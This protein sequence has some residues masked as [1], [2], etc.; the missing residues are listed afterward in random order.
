MPIPKISAP[1]NPKKQPQCSTKAKVRISAAP[2]HKF[3]VLGHAFHKKY[4]TAYNFRDN[5]VLLPQLV[6]VTWWS[7]NW[8]SIMVPVFFLVFWGGF[9]AALAM[10]RRSANRGVP[11]PPPV[12][13]AA[14]GAN[15][16]GGDDS[17][18][19]GAREPGNAI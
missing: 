9:F 13:A 16:G 17:A 4:P 1:S 6:P 7:A 11:P 2:R 14:A 10:V 18:A 19:G 3:W 5:A 15:A 12:A 8:L